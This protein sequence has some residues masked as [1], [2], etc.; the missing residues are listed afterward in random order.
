VSLDNEL[1]QGKTDAAPSGFG[2]V[3][4][5]KELGPL[6]RRNA[7][8][9]VTERKSETRA[10]SLSADADRPAFGLRFHRIPQ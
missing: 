5:V 6:L 9:R 8:T 4:E 1:T 10:V 2:A 7:R 3:A